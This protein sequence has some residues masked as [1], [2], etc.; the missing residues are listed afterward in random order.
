MKK[1]SALLRGITSKKNGDFYCLNCLHPYR[2]KNKLEYHKKVCGNKD[3]CN[4]IMRSE[5]TKI[6]E[7]NQCQKSDK[8]PFIIEAVFECMIEKIGGCKSNPENSSTKKVSKHIP[9][10]FSI[11]TISLFRSTQNKY[12]VSRGKYCMKKF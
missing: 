4:V 5:D 12:D 7:F 11:S 10:G 1:L 8:A 3:L 6:L 2:T 9:S